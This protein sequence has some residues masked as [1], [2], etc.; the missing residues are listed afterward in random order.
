MGGKDRRRTVEG[1]LKLAQV[2]MAHHEEL[3]KLETAEHGSPIRKTMNFD[4]PLCAEQFEYFAGVATGHDRGDP[5]RGPWC[6]SSPSGAPRRHRPDH[7]LE[8]PRAHG[9]LEAR[10]RHGDGQHV[11]SEAALRSAAHRPSEI[12]RVR[13]GGRGAPRSR[14]CDHRSG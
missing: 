2:I 7:T 6:S 12:G 4:V 13:H 1:L 9:G 11:R 5:A 3:A 14:E 10:G 8:L